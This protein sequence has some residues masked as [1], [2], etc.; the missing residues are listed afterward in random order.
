MALQIPRIEAQGRL[1]HKAV[2]CARE[3]FSR[4]VVI[5][6]RVGETTSF[7]CV[8]CKAKKMAPIKKV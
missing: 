5:M 3:I 2:A 4:H 8:K 1:M 6:T 7:Y